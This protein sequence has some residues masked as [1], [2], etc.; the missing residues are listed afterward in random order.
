ML[1]NMQDGSAIK[2][3]SAHGSGVL[4]LAFAHDGRIASCGRDN[5]VRTWTADGNGERTFDA[6]G[7]IALHVAFSHDD[8]RVIAG[9]WTGQVKVW[10][11]A[12]GKLAGELTANPLPASERIGLIQKQVADLQS[13]ADKATSDAAVA[14]DV[15]NKAVAEEQNAKNTAAVAAKA[16]QAANDALA[17]AKAAAAAATA[18]VQKA[19]QEAQAKQAEAQRL[20]QL[21]QQAIAARDDAASKQAVGSVH[22]LVVAAQKTVDAA[23]AV[24][25]AT[26]A[27]MKTPGDK[28]LAAKLD[29]AKA[30]L[31]S[32]TQALTD[33]QKAVAAQPDALKNLTDAAAKAGVASDQ[34]AAA[35]AAAQAAVTAQT[36]ALDKANAALPVATAALAKATTDADAATKAIVPKTLQVKSSAD[37]LAA[38][39]ADADTAG[40]KVT[41]AKAQ[42]A[43]L[44]GMPVAVQ[45]TTPPATP[46]PASVAG[47]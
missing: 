29:Q 44:K 18:L 23:K 32:A 19:R 13:A 39:K 41:A 40:Q 2:S 24:E 11:A 17:S 12:D 30:S 8:S 27:A 35:Y 37:R 33:A 36:Q 3:I 42:L 31:A 4:S 14:Q 22:G 9:D 5:L 43:K 16:V 34:A 28:S 38:A 7:D 1:W 6:F 26:A 46:L 10:A 25:D 45:P 20:A 21:K 47:K 15:F